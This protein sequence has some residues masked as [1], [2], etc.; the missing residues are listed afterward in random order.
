MCT[1]GSASKTVGHNSSWCF[2][3]EC[4][5]CENVGNHK[6]FLNIQWSKMNSKPNPWCNESEASLSTLHWCMET[7][8]WLCVFPD[9]VS[10]SP[11]FS[12]HEHFASCMPLQLSR[13]TKATWN[14]SALRCLCYQVQCFYCPYN[15]FWSHEGL[16][17]ENKGF[18]AFI[19]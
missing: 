7:L 6:R 14:I 17:S 1:L 2:I 15:V 11:G 4:R 9:R 12:Q 13:S 16:I 3:S 10:C 5:C 8:L 18:P 19:P